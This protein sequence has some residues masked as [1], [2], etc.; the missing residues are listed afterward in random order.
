MF[1]SNTNQMSK[2]NKR[3]SKN[4][5][6]DTD[7]F[8]RNNFGQ[9]VDGTTLLKIYTKVSTR[10]I[11]NYYGQNYDNVRHMK[12]FIKQLKNRYKNEG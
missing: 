10:E 9:E 3:P 5:V 1:Y 12:G 6:P 8:S 11:C 7:P 4:I 2:L